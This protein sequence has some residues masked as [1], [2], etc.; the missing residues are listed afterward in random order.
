MVAISENSIVKLVL[1]LR[2]STPVSSHID[3]FFCG[4]VNMW[5]DVFTSKHR[6]LLLGRRAGD[7][8]PLET[9]HRFTPEGRDGVKIIKR[10][11]WQPPYS[12]SEN[13]EPRIG[14]W[15]PQGHVTGIPGIF[16][17]TKAPC[18]I[19]KSSAEYI[20]IDCN[21]PLAGRDVSID[22]QIEEVS[23]T[24]KERGG[25]SGSWVEEAAANGP[26]MQLPLEEQ[27]IDYW[28]RDAFSRLIEGEDSFFFKKPRLVDH[29]D[30][31]ARHHLLGITTK[32]VAE[33]MQILDLMSSVQSHLPEGVTAYGLGL[34]SEE[35]SSNPRL[36][37]HRIHDLNKEPSL[38][39]ADRQFDGVCCH[40]SFEYLLYPDMIIGECAR[41]LR[42]EGLL[43]I[44]IS[45]RW[46]P[47]KV[48]RIWQLLH[49]FERLGYVLEFIKKYFSDI[50]TVS[51]RNWPRSA[52][53]PH[54]TITQHSDPL[55]VAIARK[56]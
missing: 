51:F 29:I 47:E 8:I 34:N 9:V 13:T 31:M 45:N 32:Y 56:N 18:R 20:E 50:E 38:P 3:H 7:Q 42:D 36:S 12:V 54:Y 10:G 39:F 37:A 27:D 24:S 40:L 48:T 53:D 28:D 33:N 26:G 25:R 46:F 17:Q 15:Y 35:M 23:Q 1:S 41:V 6:E 30:S 14:R 5:R 49:E 16:P 22:V 11:Q 52:E 43:I 2:Y 21:H 55:Y 19:V 4:E 44:S